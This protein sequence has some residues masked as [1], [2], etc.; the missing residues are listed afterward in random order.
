MIEV[1]PGY[2]RRKRTTKIIVHHT[3]AIQDLTVQDL[4][5]MHRARGYKGVGYNIYIR[6]NGTVY[7]GRGED[8]IGAHAGAKANM[9]S[10][11]VGICLSGNFEIE[12]PTLAQLESLVPLLT[13]LCR[14]YILTANA[15]IGHRDVTPTLCPGKFMPMMDIKGDVRL[16]LMKDTQPE[17][18]LTDA[19]QQAGI[20]ALGVLYGLPL[21]EGAVA[22]LNRLRRY[23]PD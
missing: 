17:T 5:A 4:D 8:A 19:H 14:K 23:F 11:S 6:K 18:G 12:Q 13:R 7:V 21:P 9:N 2:T 3:A 20:T 22:L 16:A 1:M 10:Q 15:I